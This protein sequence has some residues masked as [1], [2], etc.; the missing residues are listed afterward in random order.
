MT[1]YLG[2][3]NSSTFS[4]AESVIDQRRN[5][6]SVSEN[7]R[8]VAHA[9]VLAAV[10]LLRC[11]CISQIQIQIQIPMNPIAYIAYV[12][13]G[14]GRKSPWRQLINRHAIHTSAGLLSIVGFFI[15]A[16][17]LGIFHCLSF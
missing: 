8:C 7:Y 1:F 9:N 3:C 17:G 14:G 4:E 10:P 16:P 6:D 12:E 5:L 2:I 15:V 11:G 13:E